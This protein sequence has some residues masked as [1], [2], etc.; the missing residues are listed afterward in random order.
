M[1]FVYS[2]EVPE[3]NARLLELLGTK[4]TLTTIPAEPSDMAS[5]RHV[6]GYFRQEGL[7]ARLMGARHYRDAKRLRQIIKNSDAVYLIG[8]N[9]FEFLAYAQRIELFSM[10]SKFEKDG[11]IILSE[12]AGSIILT[13]NISTAL[14]P[15]TCPDDHALDLEKYTGMGRIPFHVS[16]HFD[17]AINSATQELDELQALAYHSKVPVM[18]FKDGEGF[19]MEGDQIV[20]TVGQP[21]KLKTNIAPSDSIDVESL[22]PLWV[23]EVP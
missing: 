12:S 13:P 8:G 15:T 17:P 1:L 2:G 14:I 21:G 10:L 5:A 3:L 23:A 22:L 19:I 7:R 4:H 18:V 11:G 20:H 16:P 9:T 6:T